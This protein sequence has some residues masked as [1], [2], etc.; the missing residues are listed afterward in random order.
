VTKKTAEA[1]DTRKANSLNNGSS[2]SCV[3][4]K[5]FS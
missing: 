3:K 2:N 5:K 1:V 4:D